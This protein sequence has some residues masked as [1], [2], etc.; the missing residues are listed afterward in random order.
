MKRVKRKKILGRDLIFISWIRR[1][2]SGTDKVNNKHIEVMQE[3]A[4]R[5]NKLSITEDTYIAC[6]FN[7]FV[8]KLKPN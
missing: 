8:V 6:G 5:M 2:G 3:E 1:D 7:S 4:F